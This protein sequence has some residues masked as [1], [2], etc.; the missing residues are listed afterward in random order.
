MKGVT[1]IFH[2]LFRRLLI[3]IVVVISSVVLLFLLMRFI[4]GS[5]VGRLVGYEYFN[6]ETANYL[7]EKYGLD[8]PV[9]YQLLVYLKGLIQGDFGYSYISN[10]SVWDV[11]SDR[12]FP[13]LVLV[14][15]TTIISF[16]L[17]LMLSLESMSR[18]TLAK[19][20]DKITAFIASLPVYVLAIFLLFILSYF[21]KLLPSVGMYYTRVE[22]EGLLK[23]IDLIKHATLPI[24]SLTLIDIA[25][26]YRIS[27][28]SFLKE[29]SKNYCNYL[30]VNGVDDKKIL[31]KYILKNAIMPS[32]NV[33][34]FSMTRMVTG[35]LYIEIIFAWPGIGSLIYNSILTRDYMVLS[36]AFFMIAVFIV[37]FMT[38]IDIVYV[39]IDPRIRRLTL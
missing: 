5:P 37:V 12:V 39:L 26:Y 38:L 23:F 14:L 19:V 10:C 15:P 13:T 32:I 30:R 21:L 2:Y 25:Y 4:P 6:A 17:G 1:S 16:L 29:Q 22:Y 24:L 9:Y 7:T 11:I 34:S 33:L 3:G 8:K 35:A 18:E 31:K 28:S 20:L 27:R 36:A